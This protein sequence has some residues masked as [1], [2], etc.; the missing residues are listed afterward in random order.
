M[1]AF[2]EGGKDKRESG[3]DG[4]LKSGGVNVIDP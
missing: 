2:M 1:D 3:D 4:F